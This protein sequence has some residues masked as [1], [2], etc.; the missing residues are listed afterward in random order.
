MSILA[1]LLRVTGGDLSLYEVTALSSNRLRV[2]I[3]STPE[4]RAI[5]N[6]PLIYGLQYTTTLRRA[7]VRILA[8]LAAQDITEL[9]EAEAV[10]LHVLRG[11]LNFGLREALGDAFGWNAHG[12]L[13]ISAQRARSL[14]SPSGWHIT[15][16][17]YQKLHLGRRHHVVFGDVVAT[18]T[19][20]FYA[21]HELAKSARAQG[22]QLA[23]VLFFTIGGPRSHEIIQSLLTDS[24]WR[25]IGL[26]R[27][28]VVFLEGIFP[29][30]TA[31]TPLRVKID[32]T[33]LL[34]QG[35]HL[36]PEFIE[37]QYERPSFPLERCTIYDA[38]SRS[39][40]IPEYLRDVKEYWKHVAELASHGV[41]FGELVAERAPGVDPR[42]YGA[43]SLAELAARQCSLC[44]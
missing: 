31:E 13:F 41:T 20:L 44:G 30:A 29:V 4:S 3:A 33:D 42:R 8:A 24:T 1:P 22:S 15:E 28:T 11:G 26:E 2:L 17:H 35:E 5:A 43:V 25:A 36:A 18:G 12:S 39:F 27:A 21:L 32:G 23:E 6:D 14:T 7:C 16:S 40:E 10:V 9:T 19:S 34:R 37:S 38:G